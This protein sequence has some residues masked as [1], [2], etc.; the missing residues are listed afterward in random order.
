MGDTGQEAE[1]V[2]L[3]QM[4]TEE[5]ARVLVGLIKD[6]PEVGKAILWVVQRCPNV[7]M[8]F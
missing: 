4:S 8:Q 5:L 1:L 7:V 6:D 2:M 3:G